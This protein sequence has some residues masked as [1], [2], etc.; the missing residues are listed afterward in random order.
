[1]NSHRSQQN[2]LHLVNNTVRKS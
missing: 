1:M 2:D